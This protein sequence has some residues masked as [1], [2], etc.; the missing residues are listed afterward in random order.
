MRAAWRPLLFAALLFTKPDGSPI[1]IVDSNIVAVLSLP[2][3]GGA[4]TAVVTMGGTFYVR[5]SVEAVA[6]KLGRK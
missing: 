3:V 6:D 2:S 1:Y 4:P 5:E